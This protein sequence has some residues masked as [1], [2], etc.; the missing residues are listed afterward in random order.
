[1]ETV[2]IIEDYIPTLSKPTYMIVGIPDAGLVGVIATEYLIDKLGLKDFASLYA[3][4]LL[5]PISHVKDGIAKSPIRFYHNS[6]IIVA[7]SWIAIP[8]SAIDPIDKEIV[9]FAKK[10]GVSTIISITGIPIE[11]RLNTENLN[12]YWISNNPE[13]SQELDKI[14]LMKKFGDGYIAGPYAPLLLYSRKEGIDNFVIVV[15]SFLDLPDPEAAAI[16]L[17]ILSRY[18]GF[19]VSVGDLLKEAEEIREKIKGLMEQT[20][21]E[22]PKYAS[23]KPMTYA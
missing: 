1:M 10:Y 14:G 16:A 3:P 5:P 21:V 20:K 11:D 7:H 13:I 12:A 19:S 18:I 8:S 23:G 6:N 15:E 17:T 2:E 4:K 22:L 9:H